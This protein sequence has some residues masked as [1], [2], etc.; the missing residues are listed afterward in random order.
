VT[1]RG[2]LQG[3][4]FGRGVLQAMRMLLWIQE[5]TGNRAD[6]GVAEAIEGIMAFATRHPAKY[7]EG[8]RAALARWLSHSRNGEDVDAARW[9][10]FGA[11]NIERKDG[12][13]GV[14]AS[15]R[16]FDDDGVPVSVGPGLDCD[17]WNARTSRAIPWPAAGDL[18]K[19]TPITRKRFEELRRAQ[20]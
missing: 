7:Q 18:L 17:A 2:K 16:L 8:F 1:W 3:E 11:P 19:L 15:H 13:W 4:E 20:P 9:V 12:S 6:E 10:P 14:P 5:S